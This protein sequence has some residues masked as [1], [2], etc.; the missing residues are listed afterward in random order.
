[1]KYRNYNLINRINKIVELRS[2]M[3]QFLSFVLIMVCFEAIAQEDYS[4]NKA[5]V[6][7]NNEQFYKVV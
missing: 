6:Q 4:A 7:S 2:S 1:M 3:R 5:I